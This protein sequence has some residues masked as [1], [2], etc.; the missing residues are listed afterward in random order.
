[1]DNNTYISK[2]LKYKEKYIQLKNNLKNLKKQKGGEFLPYNL[3]QKTW[4]EIINRMDEEFVLTGCG[5]IFQWHNENY[6]KNLPKTITLIGEAHNALHTFSRALN[7]R[8]Y[9]RGTQKRYP[10]LPQAA[11]N[12]ET[13]RLE[14]QTRFLVVELLWYM[15]KGTR[16]C[17]D[18]YLEDWKYNG[19][20][21]FDIRWE[22]IYL[23]WNL[24]NLE[25]D[26]EFT[27]PNL[28]KMLD[29]DIHNFFRNPDYPLLQNRKDIKKFDNIRAHYTEYRIPLPEY[30]VLLP[31][32][33]PPLWHVENQANIDDRIRGRDPTQLPTNNII[34]FF[35]NLGQ[36]YKLLAGIN[37]G[38]GDLHQY[39]PYGDVPRNDFDE[40]YDELRAAFDAKYQEIRDEYTS[41]G[42][43]I[44]EVNSIRNEKTMVYYPLLKKVLKNLWDCDSKT[45]KKFVTF[46]NSLFNLNETITNMIRDYRNLIVLDVDLPTNI[47]NNFRSVLNLS[48][49]WL[50]DIYNI[51]RNIKTF[52][53]KNQSNNLK[54]TS[55]CFNDND[56]LNRNVLCYD[57]YAH[58]FNYYFFYRYYFESLP[59]LSICSDN[60]IQ[61]DF[62][63]YFSTYIK[64]NA[65]T[66]TRTSIEEPLNSKNLNEYCKKY[67]LLQ[68]IY[69]NLSL[70]LPIEPEDIYGKLFKEQFITNKHY[71]KKYGRDR[72]Y[73]QALPN[74]YNIIKKI[75]INITK[76]R[77]ERAQLVKN[78]SY[79]DDI[80]S[81]M[82]S[83][84]NSNIQR[85]IVDDQ[86]WFNNYYLFNNWQDIN[87]NALDQTFDLFNKE[88]LIGVLAKG[89][90]YL[91]DEFY[92]ATLENS[93]LRLVTDDLQQNQINNDKRAIDGI[94]TDIVNEMFFDSFRNKLEFLKVVYT[95]IEE[96]YNKWCEKRYPFY[97]ENIYPIGGYP[98]GFRVILPLDTE[99]IKLEKVRNNMKILPIVKLL[100]K[101][102]MTLRLLFFDL[103]KQ[104]NIQVE[105]KLLNEFGKYFKVSDFDFETKINLPS[106]KETGL[107]DEIKENR[108]NKFN[109]MFTELS[110]LNFIIIR[111]LTDAFN[112]NY[113]NSRLFKFNNMDY[114]VREAKLESYLA[115]LKELIPDFNIYNNIGD[116]THLI[117]GQNIA[118]PS[119]NIYQLN[120]EYSKYNFEHHL[121]P[122][123]RKVSNEET[124]KTNKII[125]NTKTGVALIETEIPI[126][127]PSKEAIL[128]KINNNIPPER[129]LGEIIEE[130]PEAE[131]IRV[132]NLYESENFYQNLVNKLPF[133]DKETRTNI[134]EKYN[135]GSFYQ[136]WNS[137]IYKTVGSFNLCRI[138]YNF[139]L[140]GTYNDTQKF[141]M[142]SGGEVVDLSMADKNQ[143]KFN[144]NLETKRFSFENSDL[145]YTSY[146]IKGH[147]MDLL[148]ILFIENL[149][150]TDLAQLNIVNDEIYDAAQ[151]ENTFITP[152]WRGK[153]Y[154]KRI[155]R[156]LVLLFIQK[157]TQVG[158]IN[159][160]R[161]LNLIRRI[162]LRLKRC[163][164]DL[165]KNDLTEAENLDKLRETR[166]KILRLFTINEFISPNRKLNATTPA[167]DVRTTFDGRANDTQ[168]LRYENEQIIDVNVDANCP[169]VESNILEKI[170][171]FADES[172][173]I[174]FIYLN[175][176]FLNYY[177]Y[178]LTRIPRR[179]NDI[180]FEL[181]GDEFKINSYFE[182]ISST[183]DTIL[184]IVSKI[185]EDKY[186]ELNEI[187]P[188]NL[189]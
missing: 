150:T 169:N 166:D 59:T 165:P 20:R 116:F 40:A 164:N 54:E 26:A 45:Q 153:K 187:N 48:K 118:T 173:L 189:D 108:N 67:W 94:L 103:K 161:N 78:L 98:D 110:L 61:P 28:G 83:L 104:F 102:G 85:N 65:V 76:E 131:K 29:N 77:N 146:S 23:N 139:N 90:Y 80:S 86:G 5:Y 53:L 101:G 87:L 154:A 36:F 100:F 183:I 182:H 21:N 50:V 4:H 8:R 72:S 99:Q 115:K 155:D 34:T 71:I 60:N 175:I 158:K 41:F 9:E 125:S 162:F 122:N 126:T 134:N 89:H 7:F 143:P 31:Y 51:S 113:F 148:S 142:N 88:K 73:Y 82:R 184:N 105:K 12:G 188:K 42:N 57:G 47:Y 186:P 17:L 81:I 156:L 62:N 63:S 181:G 35:E 70:N 74:K 25:D 79:L 117:A 152:P 157:M 109:Q 178:N 10:N 33:G 93:K 149:E 170:N 135:S 185:R 141:I 13:D 56:L 2:Y 130:I 69:P 46:F 68:F 107:S 160:N 112:N 136:S 30:N 32:S 176:R 1:M 128:N 55:S 172:G 49:C 138:K 127:E 159:E 43:I 133:G 64:F 66:N 95:Y 177:L 52:S 22:P 84:L 37:I 167:G 75:L 96:A 44:D 91:G 121:E 124:I 174:A 58:T 137:R 147:I 132:F 145:D 24:N 179:Y 14:E 27:I 129:R 38:E 92:R 39:L 171:H 6:S 11:L 123:E 106:D 3:D 114:G 15:F 97:T 19:R 144:L 111:D 180:I 163:F 119:E 120:Q 16:R 151:I 140:L 18:F 168:A